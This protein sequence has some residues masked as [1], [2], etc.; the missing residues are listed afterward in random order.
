MARL[1]ACIAGGEN[2]DAVVSVAKRFA[3]GIEVFEDAV[4]FDI[5]G[6][7]NLF[8]TPAQI[9]QKIYD[10]LRRKKLQG[11]VS[12]ATN[13][14]AALLHAR[15][16]EGMSVIEDDVKTALPLATLDIDQDTLE[17]FS[18][19][20][21][22]SSADLDRINESDL[23]SRYGE[24]FR[25]VIDLLHNKSSH[26]LTPN[27]KENQVAWKSNFDFSVAE[28]EQL[29]FI[30]SNGLEKLLAKIS[31]L[32]SSTE[33][34][35]IKLGLGRRAAKSYRIKLSFPTL[36]KKFWLTIINLRIAGDPPEAEIGA[37]TLTAY[38]TRP[39]SVQRSLYAA[40]KP[41]AEQL[42]LTVDKI[43]N[44]VGASN[45]GVP[46]LLDRQVT[47]AFALN[48][49]KLPSGREAHAQEE[50]RPALALHY[51]EP[52]L[53]AEAVFNK[54]ALLYLRTKFFAGR[55]VSYGGVW[56]HFSQ[57]WNKLRRRTLE[58]DVELE[59]Q[60]LYRIQKHNR[61]WFVIGKYD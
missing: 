17:V 45:V 5:S 50:P 3:Y 19:L 39:R 1:Y 33:C 37:I 48:A 49:D 53:A 52:P 30:L 21:M 11:N 59:D 43:K 7:K 23:V 58:W 40:A 29:I 34:I 6:S 4:L 54:N 15:N 16:R 13:A 12:V 2:K 42:Q 27:L 28:F 51:F 47:R 60:S 32:G 9:A 57:W 35:D 44:L 22:T 56:K 31:G 38:F 46:E 41:E 24:E 8:G 10:T 14:A 26:V 18:S 20:G 61:D 36:D 55:V 25:G